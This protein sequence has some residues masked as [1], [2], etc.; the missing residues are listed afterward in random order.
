VSGL[1][2]ALHRLEVRAQKDRAVSRRREELRKEAIREKWIPLKNLP[3][4]ILVK[5]LA[6]GLAQVE[7]LRS[8]WIDSMV[9][10]FRKSTIRGIFQRNPEYRVDPN[11]E[12]SPRYARNIRHLNAQL[13]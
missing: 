5:H 8:G 1:T 12:S 6:A 7:R 2:M 13:C 11:D 9:E 10:S 3:P 4:K